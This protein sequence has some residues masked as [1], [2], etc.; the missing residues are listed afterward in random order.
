MERSGHD[1]Q[2]RATVLSKAVAKYQSLLS[3]HNRGEAD[4]YRSRQRRLE[5]LKAKGGKARASTYFKKSDRGLTNTVRVPATPGGRLLRRVETALA[6]A[7]AAEGTK[8]RP[9]EEAGRSAKQELVRSDP[10]PQEQCGR[11]DCP[12]DRGTG[13]HCACYRSNLN[14]E[15]SCTRCDFT[16]RQ[17]IL[18]HRASHQSVTS[19]DTLRPLYK[20]ETSRSAYTRARAHYIAYRT[21]KESWMWDHTLEQHGGDSHGQ[22]DYN[23]RVVGGDKDVM[24]RLMRESVR[25]EHTLGGK[26]EPFYVDLGGGRDECVGVPCTLLNSKRE[27]YVARIPTLTEL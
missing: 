1:Q 2:F 16:I 15:F 26:P 3:A 14:Y 21:R 20:G 9:E 6:R 5:E 4:L 18:D 11:E 12:L 27:F 22:Q 7:P 8:V 10:F 17:E 19:P 24:R 23:M 25:I 13:C